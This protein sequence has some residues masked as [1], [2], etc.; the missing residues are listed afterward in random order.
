MDVLST[1]LRNVALPYWGSCSGQGAFTQGRVYPLKN[2]ATGHNGLGPGLEP[3]A[4][5]T[6]MSWGLAFGFSVLSSC[7]ADKIHVEKR[8][9]I[10]TCVPL[11]SSAW[12]HA[13]VGGRSSMSSSWLR[14]IQTCSWQF[15]EK[16]SLCARGISKRE[17]HKQQGQPASGLSSG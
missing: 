15:S 1:P 5:P 7:V 6:E 3:R 2:L 11:L 4:V 12:W 17:T 16:H 10:I 9:L 14:L 8:S 13:I